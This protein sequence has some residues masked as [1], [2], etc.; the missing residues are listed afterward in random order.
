MD[1]RLVAVSGPLQGQIFNLSEDE[2]SVGKPGA[3][4][5]AIEDGSV[6]SRHCVFIKHGDS[7]KVRDLGSASGTLVNG[8]IVAERVLQHADCV[9]IGN[10]TLLFLIGADDLSSLLSNVCLTENPIDPTHTV[11]LRHDTSIYLHPEETLAGAADTHIAQGFAAIVRLATAIRSQENLAALQEQVLELIMEAIPSDIGVIVLTSNDQIISMFGR[12]SNMSASITASRTV[13]DRVLREKTALLINGVIETILC[14]PL[15]SRD[16][17]LGV[18]Y[19]SKGQAGFR[20]GDSHLQL[21]AAFAAILTLPLE[22]AVRLEWLERENRRL[23]N[24]IDEDRHLIGESPVMKQIDKFIGRVAL[25]DST[26]L[27]RG[28]S[29]TGKELVARALH[30]RSPR[31]KAPFVAINCAALRDELLESELFGH[32]KGAF[33]SAVAQKKGKFEVAEGGTLFLDELGEMSPQLQVKLL[34]VLQERE[35]ERVGGI[36]PIKV[37][38]RVIAAT[39]QDLEEAIRQGRFRPELYYRVNVVSIVVPPLRQ[40]ADDLI[41]LAHYFA[42]RYAA[43]Y[44][45]RVRGISPASEACLRRY[46]WP[47]NVRELQNAIERAVVLSEGDLIVPEDLP[48]AVID[49]GPPSGLTQRF[50]DG[51]RETKRRLIQKALEQAGGNHAEAAQLLAVNRTYL[52][53]LIK[54]LGL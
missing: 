16:R 46:D 15:I 40:R 2:V 21:L 33:T 39:D 7:F 24:D 52:H 17:A 48:D 50:H 28:E 31:S 10:T 30:R 12:R 37:N 42:L 8:E 51:V 45:S 44:N 27:I 22:S 6:S 29:G 54:N 26:V 20:F 19:L 36:R 35:M 47:G 53:R 4:T 18:I 34:R 11:E 32:E 25:T 1:P 14:V 43:K 13:I 49:A 38:V 5:L 3:A 9:G 41:Q 23:Q